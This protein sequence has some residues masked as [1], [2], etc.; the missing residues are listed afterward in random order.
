MLK[1]LPVCLDYHFDHLFFLRF[2]NEQEI[3]LSLTLKHSVSLLVGLPQ[4]LKE[5]NFDINSFFVCV[6]GLFL[7]KGR[8]ENKIWLRFH[9]AGLQWFSVWLSNILQNTSPTQK[10]TLSHIHHDEC[11]TYNDNDSRKWQEG[12]PGPYSQCNTCSWLQLWQRLAG[13][14]FSC[15][16]LLLCNVCDLQALALEIYQLIKIFTGEGEE[17][18]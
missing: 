16:H 14:S 15:S 1:D 11:A 8:T 3:R 4:V 2:W 13:K 18:E 10:P 17:K 5:R 9:S 6:I 12:H 7:P